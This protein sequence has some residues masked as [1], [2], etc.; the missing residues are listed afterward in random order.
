M[1][2]RA[3]IHAADLRKLRQ[4]VTESGLPVTVERDG[5]KVTVHPREDDDKKLAREPEIVL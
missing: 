5:V 3:V 1:P 2:R 4:F